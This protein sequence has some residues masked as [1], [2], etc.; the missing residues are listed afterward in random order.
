M[1]VDSDLQYHLNCQPK[2]IELP[3]KTNEIAQQNK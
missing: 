2:Q 1:N 3:T